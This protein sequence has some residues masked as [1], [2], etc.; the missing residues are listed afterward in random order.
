[1]NPRKEILH[2]LLVSLA[3]LPAASRGAPFSNTARTARNSESS[4]NSSN[5]TQQ[6]N[7]LYELLSRYRLDVK[8]NVTFRVQS[9]RELW[10]QFKETA[11]ETSDFSVSGALERR[12][13]ERRECAE[14]GN[15][16]TV[17]S[18]RSLCSWQYQCDF[19]PKRV[20]ASI[21]TAEIQ[22]G[23]T[24]HTV[25]GRPQQYQCKPIYM[26]LNVLKLNCSRVGKA[27]E[28]VLVR[29]KVT[30][31]FTAVAIA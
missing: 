13:E 3:A 21:F 27:P 15:F 31:G 1:M 16:Q 2:I 19:D 26:P 8:A 23:N 22:S 11:K 4:G 5:C 12:A 7:S 18:K 10:H 9:Q 14:I 20:P 29:E 25:V 30:V 28:W 24:I 17:V 6:A